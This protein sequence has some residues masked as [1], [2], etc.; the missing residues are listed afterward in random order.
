MTFFFYNAKIL[1]NSYFLILISQISISV[2]MELTHYGNLYRDF[3]SYKEA[4]LLAA[5]HHLNARIACCSDLMWFDD[6]IKLSREKKYT[7]YIVHIGVLIL[8]HD[9]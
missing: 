2:V 6:I 1:S 5:S 7:S 9:Y 3:V 8:W 4:F